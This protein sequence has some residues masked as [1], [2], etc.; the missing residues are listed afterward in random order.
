[1]PEFLLRMRRSVLEE[2]LVEFDIVGKCCY[3]PP[4]SKKRLFMN[5]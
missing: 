1:M 3:S 5:E 4:A 2:V